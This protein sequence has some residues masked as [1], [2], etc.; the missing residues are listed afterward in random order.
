M[1]IAKLKINRRKGADQ[2][3]TEHPFF[4]NG[5]VKAPSTPLLYYQQHF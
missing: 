5:K 1:V 2:L 3:I 4:V